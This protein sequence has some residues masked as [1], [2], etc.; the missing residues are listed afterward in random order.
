MPSD[1]VIVSF[2]SSG[3][4]NYNKAQLRMIKSTIGK[5]DGDY[6]IRSYD[7]YV[8][9]YVGVPIIT[10]SYPST[11]TNNHAEVPYNFKPDIVLEAIQKGYTKIIWCDSTILLHQDPTPML[12]YAS[13]HGV[14]AFDNLG[15]PL[16]A[17]I[18][19]L[20]LQMQDLTD[21]DLA[22]IKQIMACVI[23]FDVSN[24]A[25]KSV[26]DKWYKASKDGISFQ[27]YGSKREGFKAHRHDQAV[28]SML[29]HKAGIPL[30]PYGKLVYHPDE[31]TGEFGN[32]IYFV[33]KGL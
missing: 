18:S 20:S 31:E 11:S 10:G 9:E 29:L 33:N 22:N 7:G 26:F 24:P 12:D 30:L 32:D 13:E 5:W 19:D 15:H 14:A 17:W 2:A 3:R 25:G 6:L 1:K 28:L 27:N 21:D 16:W 8:D 4:E 23:I